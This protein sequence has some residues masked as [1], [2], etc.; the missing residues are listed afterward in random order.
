MIE[1][2]DDEF[3]PEAPVDAVCKHCDRDIVKV[4]GTWVDPQATGDDAIWR[5]TCDNNHLDRAAEHEPSE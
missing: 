2:E 1:R 5:E 4:D 3:W